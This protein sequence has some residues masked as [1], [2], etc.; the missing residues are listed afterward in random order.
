MVNLFHYF[1]LKVITFAGTSLEPLDRLTDELI[2]VN[3]NVDPSEMRCVLPPLDLST[4]IPLAT[5]PKVGWLTVI[6]AEVPAA[7]SVE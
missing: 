3:A 2:L 5:I 1:N 6:F 4:T 7:K